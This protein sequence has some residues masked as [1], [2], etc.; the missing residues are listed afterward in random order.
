MSAILP[1]DFSSTPGMDS[2]QK[3][4][5]VKKDFIELSTENP[6]KGLPKLTTVAKQMKESKALHALATIGR[7]TAGT[8]GIVALIPLVPVAMG[9][10]FFIAAA[11]APA[12]DVVNNAIKKSTGYEIEKGSI[13]LADAFLGLYFTTF[14][15]IGNWMIGEKKSHPGVQV[16]ENSS[17]PVEQAI[18]PG[19]VV[20]TPKTSSSFKSSMQ[21]EEEEPEL[22][23]HPIP[24]VT[25]FKA[26]NE[27]KRE[28]ALG[29]TEREEN[30]LKAKKHH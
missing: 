1:R 2:V 27:E 24:A 26:D 15:L 10:H 29:L 16:A 22:E 19:S 25:F 6:G 30:S 14:E 11:L 23:H 12:G 13:G 9:L 18:T 8:V 5:G 4:Q 28:A 20:I 21:A 7:V 17:V 3:T